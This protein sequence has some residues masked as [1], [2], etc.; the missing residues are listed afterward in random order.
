MVF[1]I[2]AA[3]V[4]CDL[5]GREPVEGGNCTGNE[6]RCDAGNNP[7]ECG[8]DGKWAEAQPYCVCVADADEDGYGEVQCAAVAVR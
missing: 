5:V 1:W 8:D 6:R 4:G 3:L 7:F 2:L